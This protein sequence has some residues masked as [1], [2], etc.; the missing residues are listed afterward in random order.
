[1]SAGLALQ[2]KGLAATSFGIGKAA[3]RLLASGVLSG[4][5]IGS[6]A[7]LGRWAT[8]VKAG[9]A[10]VALVGHSIMEG[11]NQNAIEAALAQI[12]R[13]QLRDAFPDVALNIVNF[14]LGG[15]YAAQ[16]A[17]SS[18]I[19]ANNDNTPTTSF[20]RP[21]AGSTYAPDAWT[22]ADLS[23]SGST[24]GKSWVQHVKDF[25]PDL[26]FFLMDLNE[27][28][29]YA[30][31]TAMD[32]ILTDFQTAANWGG[33]APGVVLGTSHTGEYQRPLIL[34]VHRAIRGLAR[35]YKVPLFDA[36][37]I[38]ELLRTGKDHLN[39]DVTIERGFRYNGGWGSA[40]TF[41]LDPAYWSQEGGFSSSSSTMLSPTGSTMRN[42][43]ATADYRT[44]RIR[45][46]YDGRIRGSFGATTT[47]V[48]PELIARRDPTQPDNKLAEQYI[49]RRAGTTLL[50]IGRYNGADNTLATVTGLP[51][52]TNGV[53]EYFEL[54]CIGSHITVK[55][56]GKVEID[57]IN[58]MVQHEG[59]WGFGQP[60]NGQGGSWNVGTT[61][62]NGFSIEFM[63][64]A[65]VFS[66][67]LAQAADLVGAV[68]DWTSNPDSVGGN[69]V[70]HM[71]TAAQMLIYPQAIAPVMRT[72][73]AAVAR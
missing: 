1:M 31:V 10:K 24:V 19:G 3:Q 69:A 58:A 72:L 41:S 60:T 39:H 4:Q 33:T 71:T 44:Y 6:T 63:D 48:T 18:Y 9:S 49:M 8:A 35:K 68:N 5:P 7:T 45:P 27:T 53:T 30:F 37:R 64:P 21:A 61:M 34:E 15:R 38:Y 59:W 66:A 20:N 54:R 36:G 55:R 16:F 46:C 17:S 52:F 73:Q 2:A 11:Q 47:G 26:I 12:I 51:S 23:I 14:G 40:A 42:S 25:N 43:N 13:R 29:V 57:V 32:T 70:N 67:A 22:S 62:T 56:N 28:S 65:Q 50:L